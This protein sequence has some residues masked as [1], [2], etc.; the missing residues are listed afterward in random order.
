MTYKTWLP[1]ETVPKKFDTFVFLLM[2]DDD[3]V[4]VSNDESTNTEHN[5][6]WTTDGLDLGYGFAKPLGW[7]PR[8]ALPP[9]PWRA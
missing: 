4:L 5:G 9:A 2:D 8:D 6:W 3:I 7:L 1:M